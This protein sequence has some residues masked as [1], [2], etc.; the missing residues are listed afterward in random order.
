MK[1][2]NHQTIVILCIALMVLLGSAC[3]QRNNAGKE[4]PKVEAPEVDIHT[5]VLTGNQEALRQHI[6]ADTDIN[7]KDPFGGSS[8]LITAALFDKGEEAKILLEGGA[9]INFQNND[10]ATALHVASFFCRPGIV[11][12]LLEKGADKTIKNRFGATPYQG[13]AGPFSDVKNTY[14]MLGKALQPMG[15]ELDYAYLEKTRPAIAEM[16]K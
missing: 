15:L 3:Q 8:P 2:Q 13:V 16:L 10:G 1:A 14:D 6:S 12:L 9:D 11:R 4:E 7:E 5:A